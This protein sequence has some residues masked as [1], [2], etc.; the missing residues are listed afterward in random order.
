M[1]IVRTATT[2]QAFVS[3]FPIDCEPFEPH[4][5]EKSFIRKAVAGITD[6][7]EFVR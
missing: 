6:L 1:R 3:G 4:V 7:K 5:Y 2:L